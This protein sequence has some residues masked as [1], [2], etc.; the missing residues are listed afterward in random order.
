MKTKLLWLIILWIYVNNVSGQTFNFEGYSGK[1]KL[2]AVELYSAKVMQT[3]ANPTI[4]YA[5]TLEGN[6][7]HFT[8]SQGSV[9]N[10]YIYT[11][12]DYGD[13][14]SVV[15]VNWKGIGKGT[16]KVKVYSNGTTL[17]AEREWKV[18]IQ[19]DLPKDDPYIEASGSTIL[20]AGTSVS[21][22]FHKNDGLAPTWSLSNSSAAEIK[23]TSD[24]NKISLKAKSIAGVQNLVVSAS[25]TYAQVYKNIIVKGTPKMTVSQNVVC[26]NGTIK[27]EIEGGK[28]YGGGNIKWESDA[29]LKLISGQGTPTATFQAIKQGVKANVKANVEYYNQNYVVQNSD[30]WIGIPD[31]NMFQL[32]QFIYDFHPN[33]TYPILVQGDINNISDNFV[34]TVSG[35]TLEPNYTYPKNRGIMLKVGNAGTRFTVTVKAQNKCGTSLPYSKTATVKAKTPGGGET[36]ITDSGITLRSASMSSSSVSVRIYDFLNG[37]LVY[38]NKNEVS[39]NI[40]NTGLKDGFY[41]VEITDESGNK[42]SSKVYK[43]NQ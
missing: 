4:S 16:L 35:A 11:Y 13:S 33:T 3:Y 12:K 22:T 27:Y 37:K 2:Y 43:R 30:V 41:I 14:E 9:D 7:G 8:N 15:F 19:Q 25:T 28:Y 38:Q 31:Y 1:V 5:W 26:L 24:P 18:E 29:S 10:G 34:W 42:T 40:Q 36:G 17:L 6:N 21:L 39:F 23:Y 32:S 20:E